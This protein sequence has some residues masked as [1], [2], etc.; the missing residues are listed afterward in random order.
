MFI[1]SL[2]VQDL[3]FLMVQAYNEGMFQN[4]CLYYSVHVFNTPL[5]EAQRFLVK[6]EHLQ[7]L[8][9]SD[10]FFIL[11]GQIR[12]LADLNNFI[13]TVCSASRSRYF[14]AHTI[15]SVVPT[16]PQ[17]FH[18]V[19]S[20]SFPSRSLSRQVLPF[21]HRRPSNRPKLHIQ[22][23]RAFNFNCWRTSCWMLHDIPTSHYFK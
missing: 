16:F 12:S 9:I 2:V 18:S 23:R 22:D 1:I 19:S 11:S 5:P 14:I 13:S 4:Q 20:P 3:Y 15:L 6:F 10:D 21:A 7:A 8:L 17:D